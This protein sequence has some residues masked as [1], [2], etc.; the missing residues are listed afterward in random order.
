MKK[1]LTLIILASL[2]LLAVFT[3]CT[4]E[5]PGYGILVDTDLDPIVIDGNTSTI[6]IIPFPHHQIH[7]GNSFDIQEVVD[8]P[9]GNVRDLQITTPNTTQWT[10]LTFI[11]Y[12]ESEVEWYLYED[13]NII[14][15]GANHVVENANRNSLNAPTL[16]VNYIDNANVGAANADTAVIAAL[17]LYHGISGA[18]KDAGDFVEHTHEIILRQNE[19]YTLRFIA[20]VAGYVSYH[21]DWYERAND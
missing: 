2:I 8:L 12:T 1:K 18:G 19:D 4:A 7:E 15:A 6:V 10:H 13:V 11:F 5:E 16:L 9:N 17:M 20:N 14:L 21:L 3:G